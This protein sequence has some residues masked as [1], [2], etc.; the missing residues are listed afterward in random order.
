M[1]S[2]VFCVFINNY[3]T[4]VFLKNKF[5][6]KKLEFIFDFLLSIHNFFLI[7]LFYN[8]NR[9]VIGLETTYTNG[10]SFYLIVLLTFQFH[11]YSKMNGKTNT[12]HVKLLFGE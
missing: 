1:S 6:Y 9:C 3:F 7:C 4:F 10:T 12:I 5:F 11:T 8:S 2:I